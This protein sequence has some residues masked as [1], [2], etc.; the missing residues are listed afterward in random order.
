MLLSFLERRCLLRAEVHLRRYPTLPPRLAPTLR[1]PTTQRPLR[2]RR[3]VLRCT[4]IMTAAS[5]R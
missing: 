4:A 3:R 2:S 1:R 5:A